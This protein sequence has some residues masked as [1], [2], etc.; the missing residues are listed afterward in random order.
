MTQCLKLDLSVNPH[1]I[2]SFKYIFTEQKTDQAQ[3]MIPCANLISTFFPS[4]AM[5]LTPVFTLLLQLS[6]TPMQLILS[7]RASFTPAGLMPLALLAC[8]LHKRHNFA[9]VQSHY[10]IMSLC[11]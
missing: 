3:A 9:A 7:C 10:S 2:K 5:P 6:R 1:R 8:L 4:L 11:Y